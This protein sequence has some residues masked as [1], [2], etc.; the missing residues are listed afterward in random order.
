MTG[1]PEPGD[2]IGLR[3]GLGELA[4]LAVGDGERALLEFLESV[5]GLAVTSIPGADGV[6]VTLLEAGRAD[7]IVAST[8]FVRAVDA[9]QYAMGQGPCIT[10]AAERRTVH[11]AS[12]EDAVD[13]P[14]FGPRTA[15]LGVHSVLSLPLVAQD[16]VVGAMNVYGRVRDAFTE[17]A[18][19]LGEAFAGPAAMSVHNAQAL[20]QAR[21]LAGEL[22]VA[23]TN[24]SVIDQAL[25]VLMSRTGIT[26]DEALARLR[27]RSQ[28]EQVKVSVLAQRIVAEAVRRAQARRAGDA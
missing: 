22:R 3:R 7:T 13:W 10:A 27:T 16:C 24:R 19:R 2:G 23:M 6:G 8:D 26:E 9:I 21:R 4:Q 20:F 1:Y 14:D 12:L 5:A 18:M 25:G 11:S 17:D 15:A 28:S